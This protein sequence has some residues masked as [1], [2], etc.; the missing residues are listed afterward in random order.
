MG[1]DMLL[2]ISFKYTFSDWSKE[3]VTRIQ[4]CVI[5]LDGAIVNPHMYCQFGQGC[6]WS[7]V[8]QKLLTWKDVNFKK[9]NF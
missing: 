8:N 6:M 2:G 3:E 9:H 1:A 4:K 5:S 7:E